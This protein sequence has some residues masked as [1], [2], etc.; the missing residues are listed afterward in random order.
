MDRFDIVATDSNMT[1]IDDSS[2]TP[3]VDG[4]VLSQPNDK[5]SQQL[6]DPPD[7]GTSTIDGMKKSQ[8]LAAK[9]KQLSYSRAR[10][11]ARIVKK[12]IAK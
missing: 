7:F 6:Y 5:T 2:V 11:S 4:A 1:P 3:I 9:L 12:S 10:V 8:R